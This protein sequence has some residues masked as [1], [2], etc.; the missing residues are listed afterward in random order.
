MLS[1][2][3]VLKGSTAA[4][5]AAPALLRG[6]AWAETG[7]LLREGLPAGLGDVARLE[8]LPG[9][10]PLIKLSY[11][12]PNYETPKAYF[13]Q[14]YTPNDA[15][16][17]RYHLAGI[18]TEAELQNW[19]LKLSGDGAETTLDLGLD[20][21]KKFEPVEIAAICLCSGNR[22]GLSTPH[23]AGVEWGDG[24]MGNAKWKGARLKDVLAKLGIKK[25]AVELIMSGA[26]GPVLETT[27]KFVKSLP[28]WKALDENVL[29]AYEM[30]GAPLPLYNGYPARLIVPGWT[31]TYWIKHV[32]SLQLS[33]VSLDNFWMRAAYRIPQGKFPQ[34]ERF[35]AQENAQTMPITEMVVNSLIT[36]LEDGQKLPHGKPVEVKGIAWDAGYGINSVEVSPDGG[37]SWLPAVLGE[38]AGRFSF[39]PW[40]LQLPISKPG[41]YVVMAKAS[42]R[43]G[44]TQVNELIF[45]PAGYHNNVVQRATV[46]LG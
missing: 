7:P 21:L 24:A 36:N 5:I 11:R 15:F 42:N 28:L 25:D 38:D 23:V 27:P 30:N 3:D 32:N 35:T 1:R 31:G 8:A 4:A 22:R 20:D 40:S 18:P 33:T 37:A 14:L 2:R 44:E 9:K 6:M 12:P 46:T 45:N 10:K 17:V 34:I 39:R 41:Q 19:R 16:F 26:D 29:I 13:D 43:V